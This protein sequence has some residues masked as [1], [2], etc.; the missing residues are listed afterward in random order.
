MGSKFFKKERLP[1]KIGD[2]LKPG[3]EFAKRTKVLFLSAFSQ[4]SGT[5]PKS[6]RLKIAVRFIVPVLA[7]F[8]MINIGAAYA[9]SQNIAATSP[10][11][12]L[13]RYSESVKLVFADKYSRP[14]LELE[15]A[16]RRVEEIKDLELLADENDDKSAE[17]DQEEAKRDNKPRNEEKASYEDKIR[18]LADDLEKKL[19]R[20]MEETGL[21]D[22]PKEKSGELCESLNSIV[23]SRS[24]EIDTIIEK[25]PKVIDRFQKCWDRANEDEDNNLK[26]EIKSRE[27][28]G[29]KEK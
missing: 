21:E 2:V 23:Q 19:D 9:D 15:L 22:Y 17:K 3:S 6:Y 4:K 27:R 29:R 14:K 18:S 11:Y 20:Y 12:P 28:K 26:S 5:A 16:G 24:R 13:K 7:V 10:L 25:R 1:K 8:S